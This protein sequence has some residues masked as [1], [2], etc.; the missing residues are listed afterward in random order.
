MSQWFSA[1]RGLVAGM[2]VVVGCLFAGGA[3]A[4]DGIEASPANSG[5]DTITVTAQKR[6][7]DLQKTSVAV[8]AFEA[9]DI[10]FN[11]LISLTEIAERTPGLVVT[12]VN[13]AEPN[14]YIRG[15]GTEGLSSNAG[16]D[17]SVVMFIDG[18]YVGRGGG[19][20]LDLFDLER[21][22]VLRGPQGTLFGKNAVGGLIH[23]I[24]ARPTEDYTARLQATVGNFD[25][26]DVRGM[27]SGP[28]ADKVFFKL[29]F[30][31]RNR[32][33]FIFNETT[34][35]FVQDEDSIGGR[36]ALR[37]VPNDDLEILITADVTRE[38]A[39]GRP[40][41][42]LCDP[43][44]ND[45]V[46]CIGVVN[47]DPRIV[48]AVTDGFLN[49]DVFGITGEVNWDTGIGTFTSITAYRDADFDFEDA[50]FS[51]PVTTE[52]IE[53]INRNIENSYQI[54]Q[55]LR[56]AST[57]FND[58]LNWVVGLYFLKESVKRDELLDQRFGALSPVLEGIA[59]FP[60]DVETK[61]YAIFGQASYEVVDRLTLTI[62]LRQ[63]WEEKDARL[64][65]ILVSG[66]RPP[67]LAV[68]YDI[69]ASA[70]WSA[71]TPK[72]VIEYEANDNAFFYVSASRGFKSGGF[73]GTAPTGDIAEV[74]YD[75]EFAWSYEIGA[76]TTWF[77]N[78][79]RLNVAAFY[80]DHED[81]QVSELI[82]GDRIVIGNAA[83]AEIY[84]VE[85]EFQARPFEGLEL[86]GSYAYLH[87]EFSDFAEGA[88]QDNTG[89]TLPRSPRH[90]INLGLQYAWSL[91]NAGFLVA[92]V[93]WTYQSRIFFEASN[94]PLEV[95]DAYD[96]WNARLA[97]Q[98]VD[99]HWEV[100]LWGK[101][102]GND[103]IKTH[104][105]AFAPFAQELA[106]FN[107]PRTYGVSVTW[108][109]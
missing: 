63:T 38:R 85:V 35:N 5:L 3:Y 62:G 60:Q 95:Q 36:A 22:E 94:T 88:T 27:A 57:A 45:G 58:R 77:D 25:R 107:A 41:T 37:F 75:P 102:L 105:V 90:Q 43:L 61:S 104:I 7:Q 20:N 2:T 8:T 97:W 106:L 24:S 21:I 53:S 19:S 34:G 74:P 1:A 39:A 100:A 109:L 50:F 78:R 99:E 14:F 47:P 70:N 49:R 67:P 9:E 68:P 28:I 103:L 80:T 15:I 31:S 71:F 76:K 81:L 87:A 91:G 79:L 55:E 84:G 29:A 42:N 30:S 11:N 56:L 16:G 89:N 86:N 40:R 93:D 59:S 12:E 33:G 10:R 4:Q 66:I 69:T 18:V 13:P 108:R 73:Q 48:N 26:I 65:G 96:I 101:N 51:T 44:F 54:S 64:Q 23:V 83:S 17:A 98:S 82:A 32:D 52:T 6:E 46:H 72:F 92:R